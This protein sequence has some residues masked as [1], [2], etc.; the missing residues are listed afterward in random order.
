MNN[1]LTDAPQPPATDTD[2]TA[3]SSNSPFGNLYVKRRV[4]KS[5]FDYHPSVLKSGIQKYGRRNEVGKG[6][7]CL[8]EMDLFSLLEWNGPVL[9]AF[10]INIHSA[11]IY[12]KH[13]T[14]GVIFLFHFQFTFQALLNTSFILSSEGN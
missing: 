3:G 4:E 2:S 12:R 11:I 8:I 9:N 10:L 14:Y 6:M 5:Y 13:S 7:W 1:P